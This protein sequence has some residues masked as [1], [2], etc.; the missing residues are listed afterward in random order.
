MSS[1]FDAARLEEYPT[2]AGVYLM[3]DKKGRILYVGKAK[4]LK[5]RLKSYFGAQGTQDTRVQIPYLL[6]K[7]CEIDVILV[8][9]EKEALLLENTLIKKHQPKYNVLLKDDKGYISLKMTTKHPWPMLEVVRFKGAPPKDG[10][11]FGP[12]TSAYQARQMFDLVGKLYPLRQCRD[13]EFARRKRPCILYQIKRCSAPCVGYVTQ[14]QYQHYVDGAIQL[15]KGQNDE[16]MKNIEEEMQRASDALEF[17][18]AKVL[19]EKKRLIESITTRQSVDMFSTK[20]MDAWALYRG[21]SDVVLCKLIVRSGKLSGSH[22]FDFA[23]CIQETGELLASFLLQH[24]F[25]EPH[26]PQEILLHDRI[27][28]VQALSELLSE[29]SGK[30]VEVRTPEKGDKKKLADLA[31]TNASAIF[32]QRK[33]GK[34][35]REK[36]LLELQE[37]LCLTRFPRRIDCFDNSHMAGKE[38]VSAAVSFVDG[39]KYSAGYRKYKIRSVEM[40]DDYAMMKEAL[41]RHLGRAKNDESLPDLIIIDGGKGHLQVARKVL[42]ALEIVSCDV[43]SLAKEMH[44]HDK[45]L[46]LERVFIPNRKD[47]IVLQK[48]SPVLF[49][50][51]NIRDEAHRFVLQFHTTRRKKATIRSALDD[52][53]GIGPKKKKKLIAAFG[54]VRALC[55]KSVAEVAA[56]PGI[57]LKDAETICEFLQKSSV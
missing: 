25:V 16:V 40:G 15:I 52:I 11:Y 32:K 35:M 2:V 18:K 4:N 6:E 29:K 20:D 47:P 55:T 27:E 51:Q 33:D 28:E 14:A 50:L 49:F 7:T 53:A 24:Y 31:C 54:S 5:S 41:E 12:Y 34:A 48:H 8:H 39:Q 3:K 44:R 45:G 42:H 37:R 38:L 19:L 43:I 21:G 10:T 30:K 23:E 1:L 22:H 36:I 17:E 9:S 56:V 13:E 57:S 26:I 46:S